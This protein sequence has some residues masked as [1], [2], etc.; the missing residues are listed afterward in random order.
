[1]KTGTDPANPL[2]SR[3]T[4]RWN[5][6]G[7]KIMALRFESLSRYAFSLLGAAAFTAVLIANTVS[8]GPV[9]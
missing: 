9:A 6:K 2:A 3:R 7:N 4:V 1:M 8:M 5:C